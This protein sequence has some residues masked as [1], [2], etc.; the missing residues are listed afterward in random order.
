MI[1]NYF[2]FF[3]IT[4]FI[5]FIGLYGVY[6]SKISNFYLIIAVEIIFLAINL[7][8][9]FSSIF[10][11]N[12]EGLIFMFFIIVVSGGEVAVFLSFFIV[13]YKRVFLSDLT[14]KFKNVKY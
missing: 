8:F 6:F 14:E 12:S 7:N 10:L 11:E 4:N 3:F 9:F 2:F 13:F 1:L 5:F